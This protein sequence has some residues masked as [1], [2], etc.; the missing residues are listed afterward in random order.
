MT[1]AELK[2]LSNDDLYDHWLSEA[3]GHEAYDRVRD[4]FDIDEDGPWDAAD[5][6]WDD[7]S[8]WAGKHGFTE[9]ELD[10][11]QEYMIEAF[12]GGLT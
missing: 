12:V 11:L 1:D 6:L 3:G 2:K 4:S 8:S 10:A 7:F 9:P 5:A